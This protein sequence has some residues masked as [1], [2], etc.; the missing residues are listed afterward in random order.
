MIQTPQTQTPVAYD[1]QDQIGRTAYVLVHVA[2]V[3]AYY[4]AQ[5]PDAEERIAQLYRMAADYPQSP[6]YGVAA[7][8]L[9][10]AVRRTRAEAA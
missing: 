6:E 3:L 4:V 8:E 5:Q 10:A 9:E 2:T 7:R 1:L